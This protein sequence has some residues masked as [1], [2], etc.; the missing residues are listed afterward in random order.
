MLFLLIMI[1]VIICGGS[2][3][4]L[5]PL[6]SK[7]LPKQFIDIFDDETLFEKTLAR[8]MGLGAKDILVVSNQAYKDIAEHFA[9]KVKGDSP[10]NIHFIYEP[11]KRNTA[12]AICLA[13]AFAK[14]RGFDGSLLIL[15]SDHLILDYDNFCKDVGVA[16]QFAKDGKFVVFGVQPSFAST[17]YGYIECDD[18]SVLS[19]TEK[20]NKDT[21]E[22][23]LKKGNYLWNAG[24]FMVSTSILEASFKQYSPQTLDIVTK[25]LSTNLAVNKDLFCQVQDISIDYAVTE[26]MAAKN[27]SSLAVVSAGFRWH[28]VGS[29]DVLSSVL[30]KDKEGNTYIGMVKS[31]NSKNCTVFSD[32]SSIV[33]V[34][35]LEDCI[36]AANAGNILVC[37]KGSSNLVKQLDSNQNSRRTIRPWGYYDELAG[38]DYAGFKVKK[39]CVHPGQRLSYQMHYKRQE[40]WTVLKGVATV[41]LEGQEFTLNPGEAIFIPIGAKH[42]LVNKG[43]DD[44]EIVELQTGTYLG[45]DDIVRFDDDYGRG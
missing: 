43:D 5:E 26:N 23:Y 21:A 13:L 44:V 39:I 8:A 20:P 33:S 10:V 3:S 31:V 7:S 42:R 40:N 1:P 11:C 32:R 24:M 22:H 38:N 19:F 45:E 25:S 15:P 4:R 35:G 9:T 28:D 17:E 41:V 16:N 6:T 37:K 34:L 30:P 18:T 12:P 14:Q 36:I 2:G 29:F 27:P